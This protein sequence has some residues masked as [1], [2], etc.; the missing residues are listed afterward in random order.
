M[1]PHEHARALARLVAIE[2]ALV[3]RGDEVALFLVYDRPSRA[4]ERPGLAR[5][6]FAE[7][8]VSDAQLDQMIRALRTIGAYVELFEGE[9]VFLAALV[10][11][12]VQRLGRPLSVV[13][14]GIGWGIGVEAFEPGRKS[15]VPAVAD[16]FGLLCTGSDAYVSALT[17][18]KFHSFLVL[19][20]LGIDAPR[21]WQYRIPGGWVDGSPK[22]GTRVI[23]KSTYEARSIGVTDESVFVVDASCDARVALIAD[24]IGQP[25]TVQEFVSGRE[26]SVPV[27]ACPDT[28]VLPPMLQVL[29]KAPHDADAFTTIADSLRPGSLA[30]TP[31]EGP[32]SLLAALRASATR[33]FD[34]MQMRG[35]GRIDFRIDNEDTPWV[36]DVAIEPGWSTTGS[37]FASFATLGVD[38][39]SFLRMLI[40]V[41]FA[42]AGQLAPADVQHRAGVNRPHELTP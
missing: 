36:T 6:Y 1:S 15:L 21:V 26:V 18:H 12:Y 13:Y 42:W 32:A 40:G 28:L 20:A 30:F 16:S 11:G 3:A 8:C 7:R 22:S 39:P 41:T 33:V 37:A 2:R 27:I 24:E 35:V 17:L 34:T 14:N 10:R 19:R 4:A 31:L 23:V 38:Y 25:V 5:T 9:Q 29:A